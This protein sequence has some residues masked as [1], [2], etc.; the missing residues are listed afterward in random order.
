MIILETTNPPP[1]PARLRRPTVLVVAE[2]YPVLAPAGVADTLR[3]LYCDD[4]RRLLVRNFPQQARR[5]I[6]ECGACGSARTSD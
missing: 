2:G 4:C 1:P 5:I 6:I 3:D